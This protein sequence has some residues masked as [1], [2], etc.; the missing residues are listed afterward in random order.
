MFAILGMPDHIVPDCLALGLF[1]LFV[2]AL[3]ALGV[4]AIDWTWK[5]LDLID[6]VQKGNMAAGIVMLSVVLGLCYAMAKVA[7]A[8]IGG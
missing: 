2:I 6:E 1:G 5:G 3:V 7:V 8:I 4:M